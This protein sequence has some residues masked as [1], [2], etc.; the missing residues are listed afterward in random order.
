RV[1]RMSKRCFDGDGGPAVK[2]EVIDPEEL[3]RANDEIARLQKLYEG[4]CIEAKTAQLRAEAVESRLE[5]KPT[6]TV[7]VQ[8][9]NNELW[10]KISALTGE[11]EA[12]KKKANIDAVATATAALAA[13]LEENRLTKLIVDVSATAAANL[14]KATDA[15]AGAQFEVAGLKAKMQRLQETNKTFNTAL[16]NQSNKK[17]IELRSSLQE[18]HTKWIDM[19]SERD[20][21]AFQLSAEKEMRA[22]KDALVEKLQHLNSSLMTKV[23]TLQSKAAD[24]ENLQAL[25]ERVD[26]L[27]SE[28][29]RVKTELKEAVESE[30]AMRMKVEKL[31][32]L[33]SE[34]LNWYKN[35]CERW[36]EKVEEVMGK[37]LTFFS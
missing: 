18:T 1:L 25:E 31:E 27:T 34:Q 21:V 14:Q 19:K 9:R 32:A 10:E 28:Y 36:Q 22:Q 12:L 26:I 30:N 24:D 16:S 11:V 35:G 23:N 33:I 8:K 29:T 6:A 2:K 3:E 15:T 5:K 37:R 13:K 20:I 4:A 17:I 7:E